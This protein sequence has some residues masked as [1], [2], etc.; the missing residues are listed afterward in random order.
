M[1]SCVSSP[2][3]EGT[4]CYTAVVSDRELTL[5]V[6]GIDFANADG[7]NRRFAIA[8]CR[9]G[10]PVELRPEPKNKH[11]SRAVAVFTDR[12]GQIGY[13]TA[14]RCGLIGGKVRAGEEVAAVFQGVGDT[15]A[16][17]RVRFGGGAPTLPPQSPPPPQYPDFEA[18]PDPGLW[19]A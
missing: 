18:D 13:L 15:A 7:S 19:G 1:A 4:S 11:D 16:F 5:A 6:V 10:D 9:P 12:G 14:E 17:I 8:L 2:A 3:P